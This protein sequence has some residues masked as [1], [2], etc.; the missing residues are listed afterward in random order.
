MKQILLICFLMLGFMANAQIAELEK[1]VRS[2]E[3]E[4][5]GGAIL[6]A[7][8]LNFDKAKPGGMGFGEIRY[9]FRRQPIDVGVQVSGNVFNRSSRETGNLGFTSV[10]CLVVSDYN[11]RRTKNI[12]LFTGLG[13]GLAWHENSAPITYI[14][15]TGYIIGGAN[16]SFCFMPRVGAEF[17]HRLRITLNYKLEEKANRHFNISAGIVFGGGRR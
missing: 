8:K 2:I 6:G 15:E 14:G 5:G 17:F 7:G 3:V 13:L 10:N 11:F 9:N 1:G 4:V 16:K 12:S